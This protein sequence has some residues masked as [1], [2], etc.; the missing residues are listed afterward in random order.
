[1]NVKLLPRGFIFFQLLCCISLAGYASE[2]WAENQLKKMTLEEKIG[3]LFMLPA[4]SN[5]SGNYEQDLETLVREY[6]IGGLVFFQGNA[7]HQVELTRRFQQAA[8]V[9]LFI[10][11]DAEW[12]LG[13][14]LEGIE[15]FARN[16]TLGAIS[17]TRYIY[18]TAAEIARQCRQMGVHINFAPVLDVNNNPLN[19]VI[20]TR[21]FGEN[22]GRVAGMGQAFIDGLQD[23]GIMAV[24]KHFPGHG[25]TGT[26]SHYS[27]PTIHQNRSRLES[28]ELYPFKAA[29][30]AGLGGLMVAH[31]Y[32]PALEEKENWPS[33]LSHNIIS[34]LLIEDMGFEGLIFTDA[35]NMK[36]VSEMLPPGKAE[37]AAFLAGNDIILMPVNIRAAID[38]FKKAI[39]SKKITEKELDRRVLKILK[40]KEKFVLPQMDKPITGQS[41]QLLNRYTELTNDGVFR[42]AVTVVKDTKGLLPFRQVE[43]KSFASLSI[44]CNDEFQDYLDRYADFEHFEWDEETNV[45]DLLSML[46]QYDLVVTG[47][48]GISYYPGRNYGIS[49]KHIEFIKKLNRQTQVVLALF[50]NPYSLKYFDEIE[51]IV[52]GY[53]DLAGAFKAVPQVL[54]GALPALGTL[55]VTVSASMQEGAGIIYPTIGKLSFTAPG[56]QGFN[57]YGLSMI[58]SVVFESI[59]GRDMPGCQVLIARNG[60]VVYEKSFGFHTYDSIMMVSNNTVYDLASVTK[61]AGSIQAL[62]MLYEEGKIDLD[63]KISH[64]IP[65][66]RQSNKEDM[67][68]RDI[69]THQAGL[70]PYMP[71]WKY[72]LKKY[73]RSNNYYRFQKESGYE[74]EI[75]DKLFGKNELPDTVW[76]WMIDSELLEKEDLLKPFEYRY[77]DMGFYLIQ[78]LIDTLSNRSIDQ[79]LGEFLY[80]PLMLKNLGYSP[81]KRLEL[82]RI[83]PSTVDN[84]F[85]N[86]TIQGYVNDEIGAIFKGIAGHAG[87]FSNA[88]DLAILMQMNLQGGYYGGEQYFQPATITEFTRRQYKN[89]RRGLG[90]DK[91]LL[92]GD[93]YN[94]ASFLGSANSYGHSGF[95]GTFVWIDPD[96]DL[97]YIFLSNRTYPDQDNRKLIDEDVRKRIQTIIYSS[98]IKQ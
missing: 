60:S 91:P 65:S 58:D 66:L 56:E 89:N 48:A 6:H 63:K 26:D 22:P 94:P 76:Q 17:D 19:P 43:K 95:T 82:D 57:E 12:G 50:G 39:K 69:L 92:I 90:W 3:Q 55:P 72:T 93:E 46:S 13:M 64:Y 24:G 36:A 75:S 52:C 30:Q 61:V 87:L 4:Y 18:N 42:K 41:I 67:I 73:D 8:A 40:K 35:M 7:L 53:E 15:P 33:S 27:L 47:L 29:F 59:R 2:G 21:S 38:E 96:Y 5:K 1:M 14:R 98:L 83:A 70:Y 84:Y 71:Y 31:L 88:Y 10:G 28:V 81:R 62:M 51:T 79:Y 20:N 68:I 37:V 44:E 77:S 97:I 86:E 34:K 32:V 49:Q 9:P 11:M 25:D 80:A 74:I 85:R 23:N 45:D 16:M 54:F 78:K